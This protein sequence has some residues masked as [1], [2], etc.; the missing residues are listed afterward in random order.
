[1][2]VLEGASVQV[3]RND[4]KTLQDLIEIGPSQLVI[5][6]GPGHPDVDGGIRYVARGQE[7]TSGCNL[8]GIMYN[9]K[10]NADPVVASS[11][12]AIKYFAGKIPV[13]G[14][15]MGE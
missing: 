1:M 5:S 15:C 11:K 10:H 6:P 3:F 9:Y 14:V 2:Q 7:D 8:Y 4:E 12:E 13:L